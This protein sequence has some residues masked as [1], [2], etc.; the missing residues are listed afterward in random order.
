MFK[1]V[2]HHVMKIRNV[3]GLGATYELA[4]GNEI[5]TFRAWGSSG[6]EASMDSRVQRQLC[7]CRSELMELFSG[8]IVY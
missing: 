6:L 2:A 3:G 1:P 8:S 7:R 4:E 5:F